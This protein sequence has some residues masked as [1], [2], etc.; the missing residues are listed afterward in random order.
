MRAQFAMIES[1]LSLFAILSAVSIVA[2]QMNANAME[3]SSGR[4]G[5]QRAI[6]VYDIMNALE[7]N[8]S[9]NAC[10]FSSPECGDALASDY[11]RAFAVNSIAFFLGGSQPNTSLV[12][13]TEKCSLVDSFA[14]NETEELCV[15]AGS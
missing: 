5:I 2:S 15:V 11:C 6:A 9:A 3:L 14:T 7:K 4:D 10:V 13:S 1:T 8:A 12:N